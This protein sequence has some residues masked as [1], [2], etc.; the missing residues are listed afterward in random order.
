MSQN[1]VERSRYRACC[2]RG[3]C[4]GLLPKAWLQQ[5]GRNRVGRSLEKLPPSVCMRVARRPGHLAR[6][7]V[8]FRRE[9]SPGAVAA[10]LSVE[11]KRSDT[12]AQPVK[13]G[14]LRPILR[15]AQVP[16]ASGPSR[17]LVHAIS[18]EPTAYENRCAE[19]K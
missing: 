18:C 14:Y 12:C 17:R 8:L 4:A 15:T 3:T 13:L 7:R 11:L 5:G 2:E 9:G 6:R 1:D 10:P 19:K 16:R